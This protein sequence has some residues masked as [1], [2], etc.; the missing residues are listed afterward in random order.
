MR[1]QRLRRYGE[2]KVHEKQKRSLPTSS[3]VEALRA[4]LTLKSS[5]QNRK[6]TAYLL[7]R[8]LRPKLLRCDIWTKA[9]NMII[10]QEARRIILEVQ[11]FQ[12]HQSKAAF[13]ADRIRIQDIRDS[14]WQRYR[15]LYRLPQQTR[16]RGRLTYEAGQWKT[17][18]N[19]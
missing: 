8:R 2:S 12:G 17:S 15:I 4:S 18:K 11:G 13:Q 5:M 9:T 6:R 10:K 14:S 16:A 1:C 3:E 19:T 7:A